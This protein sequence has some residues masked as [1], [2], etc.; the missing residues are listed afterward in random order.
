MPPS[1]E[2]VELEMEIMRYRLLSQRTTDAAFLKRI[3][4]RAAEL[5]QKLR[6]IDE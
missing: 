2:R 3:A 6:E 5:E 1:N 4:E